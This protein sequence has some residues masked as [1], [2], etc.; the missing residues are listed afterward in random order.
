MRKLALSLIAAVWMTLACPTLQA[1]DTTLASEDTTAVVEDS[2]SADSATA[3]SSG[4]ITEEEVEEA[5]DVL[6]SE[7]GGIHAFIKDKMIDGGVEF[8]SIVLLCLILGL[9]IAIER[10]ISLNLASTNVKKFLKKVKN[11]LDT[12]G[13]KGAQDFCARTTGPVAG[14]LSRFPA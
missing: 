11:K 5:P 3:S 4:E 14:I 7:E 13:V 6:D 2:A 10:V 12:D 8:M 1:Q 9:A